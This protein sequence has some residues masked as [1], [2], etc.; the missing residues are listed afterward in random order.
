MQKR[1]IEEEKGVFV[2]RF[3]GEVRNMKNP[4]TGFNRQGDFLFTVNWLSF[5]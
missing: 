5:T 1:K 3:L 4:L 2:E